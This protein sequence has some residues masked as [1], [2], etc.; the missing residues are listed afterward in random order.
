MVAGAGF[1][2]FGSVTI[3]SDGAPIG[4]ASV[5]SGGVFAGSLRVGLASGEANKT[6]LAT[7]NRNPEI[8]GA[9][10][11]RVSALDVD[12]RPRR[13][14]PGRR[15]RVTARGF[16]TGRR[17]YAH[18]VRGRYRR[19]VRIGT[20][21]EPCH[22]LS[23]RRRIFARGTRGGVYTVQFD[24]RRRYSR[25]TQVRVRF[26]VVVFRTFR[27]ASAGAASAGERWLPAP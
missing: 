26:S 13:G 6:Y 20:L 9:I 4:F 25:R 22:T 16:T 18:V 24:T 11:L 19:N 14:A 8:S 12:V 21:R 3:R 2:P 27:R 1:T 10:T 23:A 17:L 7:D 15:T 5:N